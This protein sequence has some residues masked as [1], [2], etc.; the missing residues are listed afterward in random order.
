M[1]KKFSKDQWI[2]LIL[3]IAAVLMWAPLGPLNGLSVLGPIAVVVLG[4]YQLFF[5]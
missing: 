5:R 4:I 2:G 1:A 3:L